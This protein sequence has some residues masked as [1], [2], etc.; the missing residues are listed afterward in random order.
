MDPRLRELP[1][2]EFRPRSSLRLPVHHVPRARFPV[3]DAHN[4]LGRWLSADH[5]WS[6]PDVGQLLE[7]MDACNVATVV[8]LDGLQGD[9]LRANL[10]RYDTPIRTGSSRSASWTGASPSRQGSATD[11]R[12]S[13]NAASSPVRA[14]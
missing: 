10:E 5:G 14:G 8:N 13:S 3:V 9:E 1:L 2:H 7:V 6:A 11:S 4:H 12:R